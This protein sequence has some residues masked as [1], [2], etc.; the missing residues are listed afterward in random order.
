MFIRTAI[1]VQLLVLAFGD[2]RMMTG[3]MMNR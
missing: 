2:G 1:V 3:G